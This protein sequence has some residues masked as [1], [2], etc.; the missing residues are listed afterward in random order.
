MVDAI[1]TQYSPVFARH[2]TFHPRFGWLKKGY[3]AAIKNHN[4]FLEDDAAVILGVGKNMVRSIRYWCTAFGI[5]YDTSR[6][7]FSNNDLIS[8]GFGDNLFADNGWDPYLESLASL[9]LLHWNLTKPYSQSTAWEFTFNEF[10]LSE[11]TD[12]QLFHSL[13]DYLHKNF[14]SFKVSPA[15]LKKDINCILRMYARRSIKSFSDES[16][17]CPFVNLGLVERAGESPYYTFKVGPKDGL[18]PEIIVSTCL[19]FAFLHNS[20]ANSIA[21]SRLLYEYGSP[22]LAFKLT[23]NDLFDAI[24]IVSDKCK[25]L[26][27]SDSAGIIQLSFDE[28][29]NVLSQQLLNNYFLND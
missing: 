18:D 28:N 6:S 25:S 1:D 17:D 2:E 21:L 8:T 3:D 12:V 24:E 11:F 20:N 4:I 22:G 29:P 19:E 27:V 23:E 10:H 16:L 7:K 13:N 5:L 9:W 14:P 26:S 15:S